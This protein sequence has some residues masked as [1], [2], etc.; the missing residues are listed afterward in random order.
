MGER[1][2]LHS[3][4]NAFYASVES[5]LNPKLKGKAMAVCGATEKR[6]GIVL[7]KSQLAKEAGI[8]TG[9]VN[10]EAKQLCPN[11]IL[12]APHYEQYIKYSKLAR[13]IYQRYTG[14]VEPFGMDECY[15]DFT[16]S[17]NLFGD[18][19][20]IAEEI[21][22]TMKK[23]LGLSVSIGVSYNKCFE[24]LVGCEWKR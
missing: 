10:W 15:L 7:A 24:T 6:H 11:L 22:Q 13:A 17:T 20:T 18:G 23:E 3:D 2:I 5:T 21:R 14:Y 4:M 1:V 19:M 9:M 8:K 16:G 12:V